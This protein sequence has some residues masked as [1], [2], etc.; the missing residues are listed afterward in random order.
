ML[1]NNNIFMIIKNRQKT[2]LNRAEK[3][4]IMKNDRLS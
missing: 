1:I 3:E 2:A 4:K